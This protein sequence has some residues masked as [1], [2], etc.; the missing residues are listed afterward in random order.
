MKYF[1]YFIVIQ[2]NISK[3]KND[4]II[5]SYSF[6]LH[7]SMDFK[8]LHDKV[9]IKV[10]PEYHQLVVKAKNELLLIEEESQLEQEKI[11]YDA[12]MIAREQNKGETSFDFE[13]NKKLQQKLL[14]AGFSIKEI[15]S[16]YGYSIQTIV[17]FSEYAAIC[18]KELRDVLRRLQNNDKAYE[19]RNTLL[20]HGLLL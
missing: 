12:I 20:S 7:F 1:N 3:R 15:S 10:T 17:R 18:D 19:I 5:T 2:T 8:A 9:V 4:Y 16:N 11:V 14:D 13:L 6:K